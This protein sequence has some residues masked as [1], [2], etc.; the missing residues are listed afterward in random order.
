MASVSSQENECL[1]PWNSQQKSDFSRMML[2]AIRTAGTLDCLE[3]I[4]GKK[5]DH[6]ITTKPNQTYL[7]LLR[8]FTNFRILI[9]NCSSL[10]PRVSAK[11]A[12][13][14]TMPT[15]PHGPH[16]ISLAR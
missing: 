10:R 7:D 13:P 3:E 8:A 12:N 6:T 14:S 1:L 5:L 15:A 16:L 2:R 9:S 4:R 11:K